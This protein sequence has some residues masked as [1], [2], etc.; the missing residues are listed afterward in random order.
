MVI[1]GQK[2]TNE[3]RQT[4]AFLRSNGLRITCVEFSFFQA[5]GGTRLLSQEIVVGQEPAKPMRVSSGSLPLVSEDEFM[6]AL[7]ENGR[8]IFKQLLQFAKAH[9]MPIHWGTKGFSMNVD[10]HGDHVAVCYGYPPDSVYKQSIYTALVGRG[11]ILSKT[12]VSEEVVTSLWAAGEST[13]LF[14]PA[15]REQKCVIDHRFTD[16]DISV[17]LSWCEKVATAI[18]QHGLKE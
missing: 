17:L 4:A 1:V 8:H 7:D 9:A 12:A 6:Q 18:K 11:G 3:V 15:G 2:I 16:Q 14:R 10:V 13:G 5:D